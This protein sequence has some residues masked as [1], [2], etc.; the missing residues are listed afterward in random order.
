[1]AATMMAGKTKARIREMGAAAL[2]PFMAASAGRAWPGS[3]PLGRRWCLLT[4][5]RL[6]MTQPKLHLFVCQNDRPEGG[7][8]ACQTRGSAAVLAALQ[9]APGREPEPGGRGA[10][11]AEGAGA[12][13]PPPGTATAPEDPAPAR[14]HQVRQAAGALETEP[15]VK[16][17]RRAVAAVRRDVEPLA[18]REGAASDVVDQRPAHPL[19]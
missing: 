2:L 16:A 7:R 13:L 18:A 15:A 4:W 19:A 9:R 5:P 11:G 8:P 12:G 3:A 14:R 6:M 10:A 17:S 1:M